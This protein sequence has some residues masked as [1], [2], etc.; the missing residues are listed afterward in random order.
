M[1]CGFVLAVQLAR[2]QAFGTVSLRI[3]TIIASIVSCYVGV[4][5]VFGRV[6]DGMDTVRRIEM[7]KTYKTDMPVDD[8]RIVSTDLTM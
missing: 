5:Q 1:L 4:M 2:Q 7:L 8:V 3:P 6:V